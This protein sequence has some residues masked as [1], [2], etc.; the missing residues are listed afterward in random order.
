MLPVF[1]I[2]AVFAV[3]T[4]ALTAGTDSPFEVPEAA[5]LVEGIGRSHITFANRVELLIDGPESFDRRIEL[6]TGAKHHIFMSTYLW[7][8]DE[9][10]RHFLDVVTETIRRRRL[11]DPEFRAFFLFDALSAGAARDPFHRAY[12]ELRSAGAK[13]RIFNPLTWSIAPAYDGRLHEKLLV[14]D[15]RAAIIGSRNIAD[16]YF[17]SDEPWHNVEVFI[18]GEPSQEAQMH[19]LKVWELVKRR[20]SWKD[21]PLPPERIRRDARHFWE[22]GRFP[23]E[24]VGQGPLE[25][26]MTRAFFPTVPSSGTQVPVGVLYDNSLIWESAPTM[27]LAESLI[28]RAHHEIVIA[29]PYPTFTNRIIDHLLVAIERGVQVRVIVNSRQALNYGRRVWLASVPPLARLA[30]SG[31]EIYTWHGAEVVKSVEESHQCQVTGHPGTMLHSKFLLVDDIVGMVHS[32]NFNYR[33]AHYNSE[34][35]AVILD[36]AFNRDLR[37]SVTRLL[38]GDGSRVACATDSGIRYVRLPPPTT[39][40]DDLEIEKMRREL[41]DQRDRLEG[42]S[43]LQ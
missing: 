21:F 22:T 23:D 18:E 8:L 9:A 29:S 5:E 2:L 33:S 37:Q 30:D 20:E 35:G 36:P 14:V 41:G 1:R 4:S 38:S 39:R 16:E 7:K 17:D 32:S 31:A 34:L 13:V 6:V 42:W 3:M 12:R 26:Y 24:P 19:F 40:L 27:E 10:G 43:F 28:D 11:E 15:G 25:P